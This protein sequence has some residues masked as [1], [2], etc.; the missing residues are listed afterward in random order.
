MDHQPIQQHILQHQ[1]FLKKKRIQILCS[2]VC[3]TGLC[4]GQNG[5]TQYRYPNGQVSSEG[6]LVNGTPEGYWKSW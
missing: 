1:I 6:H 3:V 2:F 5:F 4:M